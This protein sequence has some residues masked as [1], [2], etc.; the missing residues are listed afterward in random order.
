[1]MKYPNLQ[2]RV[3]P[4]FLKLVLA[5]NP[6]DAKARG[7]RAVSLVHIGEFDEALKLFDT[8][9]YPKAYCL[10]RLDKHEEALKTLEQMPKDQQGASYNHLKGQILYKLENKKSPECYEAILSHKIDDAESLTNS[11]AS[12]VQGEDFKKATSILEMTKTP[13]YEL[14]YNHACALIGQGKYDQAQKYLAESTV[15]CKEAAIHDELRDE[16][17]ADELSVIEAQQAYATQLSNQSD[18]AK[19]MYSNL[20]KNKHGDPTSLAIAGNNLVSLRGNLDMFDSAKRLKFAKKLGSKLTLKQQYTIAIN[21]A[22][23]LLNMDKLEECAVELEQIKSKYPDTDIAALMT[24]STKYKEKDFDEAIKLLNKFTTTNSLLTVSQMQLSK[25]NVRESVDIL[26]KLSIRH[27]PSVVGS[28]VSLYTRLNEMDNVIQV[29]DESSRHW[30]NKDEEKCKIL[31][32]ES[33]KLKKR[34]N[35][36]KEASLVFEKL[37]GME[38]KNIGYVAG[39]VSCL[40]EFDIEKAEQISKMLPNVSTDDINVDKLEKETVSDLTK[41]AKSSHFDIV[42]VVVAPVNKEKNKRIKK[43]KPGKRNL[44]IEERYTPKAKKKGKGKVN[45]YVKGSQGSSVKEE[46]AKFETKLGQKGK[47][48]KPDDVVGKKKRKGVGNK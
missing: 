19:E 40:V 34:L 27:E 13:T 36:F 31:L 30:E 38:P 26:M 48:L 46:S 11:I 39:L 7:I 14:L 22:I 15:V 1:M 44:K 17:L 24:A 37:V 42:E 10:Y 2:T 6:K 8:Q 45:T 33:A 5:L 16:D 12:F 23:L 25:N 28:I 41:K 9:I 35:K 21:N 18:L 20:L 4:I 29:L 3:I 43:K 32:V 47:I